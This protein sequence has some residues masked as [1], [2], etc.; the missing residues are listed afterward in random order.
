MNPMRKP[1]V[2][3]AFLCTVLGLPGPA[4]SAP[5]IVQ[6]AAA[7][8]PVAG[9]PGAPSS[10]QLADAKRALFVATQERGRWDL[11]RNTVRKPMCEVPRFSVPGCRAAGR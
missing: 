5:A 11:T 8:S 10:E 1:L 6:A 2:A 7:L 4:A 9:S 3:A